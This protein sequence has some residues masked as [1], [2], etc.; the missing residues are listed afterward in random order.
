MTKAVLFDFGGTLYDY[1][2][3]EPGDR[4]AIVALARELGIDASED[5][6]R[7][8][9]RRA[10][11]ESYARLLREPYYLHRDFFLEGVRG[12]AKAFGAECTLEHFVRYR[13][14][15]WALQ[16]RDF[17]LRPGVL[18]TLKQIRNRGLRLGVVSNIDRDQ[19]EY[20]MELA[21]IASRFHFILTSE[22][23][24][25]CKPDPRIFA[26]ALERAECAPG[27][28]IFVGD[29]LDQDIAGA[30]RAGIRAVLI[31]HREDREPP[32][33]E[34][35]PDHVIRRIPDVMGLL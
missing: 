29:S 18:E 11:K 23:A 25:S 17:V 13:E 1:G 8:A 4:E 9:H 21:G 6:V 10:V 26:Q 20:M 3:L 12:M 7:A 5:E 19:I 15:Q 22:E 31:W 2:A 16:K 14:R 28:A 24:G 35:P 34:H 33:K 27:E 30:R 32:A